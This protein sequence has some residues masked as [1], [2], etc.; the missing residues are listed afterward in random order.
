MNKDKT[1]KYNLIIG[2]HCSIKAPGYLLSAIEE[3]ISYQANALMIYLGPPQNSFRHSLDIFKISEVKKAIEKNKLD[4][5]NIVVHG[6]YLINLANTVNKKVFHYSVAFLQKEIERMEEIGLK[7][8]ILHP[9]SSLGTK[10]ETALWQ[11][12]HGLNA[13]LKKENKVQIAL[14]TMAGKNNELGVDFEQLKFIIDNVKLKEKLGVC[15]DTCHLYSAGYDIKNNLE[16]VLIEFNKI[17]GLEKLWVIHLNDSA[18]P[19]GAKK[20]RH[21]NIGHGKIGLEALKKIVWHP[22]LEGKIKLLETPRKNE[23][24][25]EEIKILSDNN[26]L[27]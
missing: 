7:T 26:F 19:L 22:W 14:E 25:K 4:I 2:R 1:Q 15:W 21:E 27:T 12:V 24:Y 13:V 8:M 16:K 5:N 20:D 18:F 10:N 9:G 17:I 23:Y 11:I 3:T 6:S